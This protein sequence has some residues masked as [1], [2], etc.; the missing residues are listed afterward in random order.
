MLRQLQA[1]QSQE[2]AFK[3]A[4]A[5]PAAETNRE[6]TSPGPS[7]RA[8]DFGGQDGGTPV[9]RAPPPAAA[10][11]TEWP[12]RPMAIEDARDVAEADP[13]DSL[14]GVD[15]AVTTAPDQWGA[16]PVFDD[17]AEDCEDTYR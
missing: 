1:Q 9:A 15:S 6:P 17:R 2:A 4:A 11:G 12:P 7:E 5:P 16:S 13:F 8:E 10:A 3:E 14:M